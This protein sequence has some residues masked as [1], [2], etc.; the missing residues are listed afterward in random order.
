MTSRYGGILTAMVAVA[1]AFSGP[2]EGGHAYFPTEVGMTWTYGGSP[3]EVART[4]R[5]LETTTVGADTIFLW[6]GFQGRRAVRVQDDGKVLEYRDEAWRMLFDLGAEVGTTWTLEGSPASGDLMDGTVVTVQSRSAEVR[7]P[8]GALAP[9]VHLSLNPSPQLAD[10]GVVDAWFAPGVGLVKW[11]EQSIVGP[12]TFELAALA[13]SDSDSAQTPS[14]STVVGPT[15]GRDGSAAYFPAALGMTWT[16]GGS[17]M[18]VARSVRILETTP[19]GADTVF[20]WDGFQ[21]RRAVRVQ[22]DGKVLE[23]REEKWR[24][25]FDLGAEVGAT[26]TLDGTPTRGDLIDGTVVTVRSRTDTV[27]VPYGTLSPCIH[28]G[29]KP[30]PQLADAGVVD[31][32]FAP[33]IGLVKWAENSFAGPQTYELAAFANRGAE[34]GGSPSDTTVVD[35]IDPRPGPFPVIPPDYANGAALEREGV[36]YEVATDTSVYSHGEVIFL[37]YQVTAVDRDSVTFRFGSTQQIEFILVDSTGYKA[38]AWSHLRDFGEALTAFTLRR[39]ESW[40]FEER[41]DVGRAG[42]PAGAYGLL[43]YLPTASF[44]QETVPPSETEVTVPLHIVG[45]PETAILRGQVWEEGGDETPVAGAS[46]QISPARG[47]ERSDAVAWA[48]AGWTN[49]AGAFTFTNLEP[50]EYLLTVTKRGF[51]WARQLVQLQVGE[52]RV[53]LALQRVSEDGYPNAHTTNHE[54]LLAEL[55]TDREVYSVGDSVLVRYRLTNLTEGALKLSFSSGQEYDLVL[56]GPRGKVWQWSEGRLFTQAAWDTSLGAGEIYEVKAAVPLL[57]GWAAAGD[58]YLLTGYLVVGSDEAA[59][60]SRAQTEAMVKFG[61]A[62]AVPNPGLPR[63]VEAHLRADKE[64]YTP[65]DSVAVEYRLVNVTDRPQ[66]LVFPSG[67]QY[68]LVLEGPEG[69]IW[70]WSAVRL[71]ADTP[72]QRTLAPRE[73]FAFR[74]ALHLPEMGADA[75]GGYGLMAYLTV[76]AA[77]S[78]SITRGETE[79]WTKFAVSVR[80]SSGGETP[81]TP[82]PDFPPLD[83]DERRVTATVDA[84]AKGDSVVVQYRVLNTTDDSLRLM[85]RSGQSYELVLEGPNGQV[86]RWS[87]GRG[88]HDALWE[89]QL[90]PGDSLVVREA[91]GISTAD[92]VVEGNYVLAA[93]ST[94]TADEPGS[95]TP[96]ET[97]AKLRLD[98]RM[99]DELTIERVEGDA[100]G[101]K[102]DQIAEDFNGDGSVSFDDFVLFATAFE[103]RSGMI[104]YQASFDLDGDGQIAFPDLVVFARAFGK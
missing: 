100:D 71:F 97:V 77:D 19:V 16:Y 25:L 43:A 66:T 9:C 26:W 93:Y 76:G 60:V 38:W 91:F 14:D 34:P 35:P 3:L 1:V 92:S 36:R 45:D 23:L 15:T 55:A 67:Q 47:A 75:E 42:L 12:Q 56:E 6:D 37:R 103:K 102:A 49:E 74:E 50:G 104:G 48:M 33:G 88:F 101:A 63:R 87:E 59:A 22:D 69:R 20:F 86:W 28:L 65:G 4:V 57:E 82:L 81:P 78:T 73:A 2:A 29:L 8:Y 5:I 52:N 70:Q 18:E 13:H 68:D 24:T 46:V 72:S 53:E 21:G 11:V 32:W 95:L 96:E 51:G 89:Q 98:V 61:I 30:G 44:Q 40:T 7:V 85:Y 31:A 83:P 90:A 79:A 84:E 99:G 41:L 64:V 58:S 54:G 10:A 27:T 94:V 62:G 17:P 39:G 80:D